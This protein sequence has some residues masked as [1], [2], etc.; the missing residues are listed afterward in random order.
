M[1]TIVSLTLVAALA[2]TVPAA[3]AAFPGENGRI[4]YS[5][6][7]PNE[8]EFSYLYAEAPDGT[9]KG[10]F[11]D[12][13]FSSPI[14][15]I[16]WSP[17]GKKLAYDDGCCTIYTINADGTNET[18]IDFSGYD[19]VGPAWSPDG[20]KIAFM[21][22]RGNC[23]P[24]VCDEE[25]FV[26]NPDGS[27]QTPITANSSFDAWPAWSPGG[28]RIAFVSTRGPTGVWAMDSDGTNATFLA[29][30]DRPN[31]APDGSKL[32]FSRLAGSS[33]EIFVMD[34]D[35]SN[36]T[37]LTS[38]SVSDTDPAWSPDGSRIVWVHGNWLYAMNADGSAPVKIGSPDFGEESQ[39]A[40]DWQPILHGYVRPKAASPTYLSLVPAYQ[41]CTAPNRTH[42]PPLSFDS[43]APPAQSSSQLTVGTADSNGAPTKSVAYLRLAAIV[44][45]PST[46]ADEADV[47][48]AA[49][50]TDVRNASDLSDHTGA[51]E[52]RLPIRITDKDN[53]PYPGGPGP[54]TV[55]DTTFS[56]AV[57]CATTAD[58]TIGSSCSVITTADAVLSGAITERK[59][60]VWQLDRAEVRD[61]NGDVFLAQGL[62]V[63]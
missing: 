50:A 13:P 60:A 38:D 57:P 36:Q 35:G 26:M 14:D 59:R 56:F 12:T 17:D 54:G 44:G 18:E 8:Y 15:G 24:A 9:G 53:T 3:H 62:F 47:S 48:L 39:S 16:S 27:A 43:C 41:P 40:P 7:S 31:W 2:V 63:P 37:Q 19:D 49:G 61:G 5:F 32:V 28:T 6:N 52:A 34:A 30:G 20:S 51:L 45:D 21:S 22:N 11:S 58:T 23:G 33:Q 46:P 29:A 10:G 55:S 42:G 4:A 1:R 25:L